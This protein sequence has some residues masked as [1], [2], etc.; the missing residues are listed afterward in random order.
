[1]LCAQGLQ[2]ANGGLKHG[3]ASGRMP[4]LNRSGTVI[5]DTPKTKEYVT[6]LI[7]SITSNNPQK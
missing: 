5:T 3:S 7:D 2:F 6:G 4:L 1:M